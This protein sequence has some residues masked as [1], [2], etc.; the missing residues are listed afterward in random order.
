M[1]T[2]DRTLDI[3]I[4]G[5]GQA[6]LALGYS[7]RQTPYHFQIVEANSRI[8]DSWR[9]RYDSLV[10]FTPRAFSALPGLALAGDP[11]GYASRDEI[12]EY[13]ETYARHF[14]LPVV[15]GTGIQSL[16]RQ[17]DGYRATTMD[18]AHIDARAVVL[19]TGAFQT[20]AIPRL[21]SGLSSAVLQRTAETYKNP[22]DIPP[23]TVLV[24]GDGASGRDIAAELQGSHQV[25]L[26]TGRPRRLL[27][28][29]ILGKSTW[30]WLHTFGI[31]RLSGET[32]IGRYLKQTDAFPGKGNTLQHLQRRG[33]HVMPRLVSAQGSRVTFADGETVEVG[34]VI[35][36]AGY[37]DKSDWVAIPEVKDA[38]GNFVHRQG[39]APVPGFYFIG[40]P[41]QRSRGSA[42]ILGVGNDAAA[43][44]GHI[45][46]DLGAQAR[47]GAHLASPAAGE[48]ANAA[49]RLPTS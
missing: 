13:L 34:V 23:G 11:D 16:E 49:I 35:W 4:I 8:G 32:L 24:V 21:A 15:T 28:E 7:L 37:R 19:A 2:L 39:R 26:A 31:L 43:I 40:R 3:L 46:R 1:Q 27:P 47:P 17:G 20:P 38:Q 30:W 33:V 6:G 48:E 29:R 9:K 45:V 44:R 14:D 18:G 42:L 25:I 10:L 22:A 41:W 5:G 36:T 12:A